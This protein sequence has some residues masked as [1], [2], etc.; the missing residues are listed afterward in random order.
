M[1]MKREKN[2]SMKKITIKVLV[3]GLILAVVGGGFWLSSGSTD[4]AANTNAALEQLYRKP[5][6]DFDYNQA[7]NVANLRPATG[8]QIAALNTFKTVN[9]S[10]NATYRF[11]SFSGS[12]DMIYD[13]ASQPF[14]G[15]AGRSGQSLY[16]AERRAV[17]V[18]PTST[19]CA[20]FQAA[21]RSAGF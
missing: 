1:K 20:C 7:A 11:N 3:A 15:N 13:F 19:V 2:V 8:E 16:L 12:P 17:S 18:L 14:T 4:A 5:A 9:N 10:P 6:A 21:P